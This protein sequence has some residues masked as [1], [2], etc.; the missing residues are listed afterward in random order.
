MDLALFA[1]GDGFN[2]ELLYLHVFLVVTQLLFDVRNVLV[3]NLAAGDDSVR[4][5]EIYN[6]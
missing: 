1:G 3:L 2:K 5:K 6:W 4:K